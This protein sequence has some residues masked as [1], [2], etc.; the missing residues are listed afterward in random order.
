MN[1]VGELIPHFFGGK[2][3]SVNSLVLI[4]ENITA[5]AETAKKSVEIGHCDFI[6]HL[7]VTNW[8]ATTLDVVLEHSP[9]GT[10]WFTL[11]TFPQASA[12]STALLQITDANVHVLPN[13]RADLTLVGTDTDV[14]VTLWYDRRK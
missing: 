12:N 14:K 2:M 11:A 13:V 9:N 4:D 10:D 3:A 1:V 6:G 5:S 7:E 8:N